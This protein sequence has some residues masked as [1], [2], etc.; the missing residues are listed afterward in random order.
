MTEATA[1]PATGSNAGSGPAGV[2]PPAAAGPTQ[3]NPVPTFPLLGPGLR[4]ARRPRVAILGRDGSGRESIFRAAAST[5]THHERLA[6]IGP[7]YE[8][9]LVEVGLD[10]ISL[11]ALP[12]IA[13]SHSRQEEGRVT[14]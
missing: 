12:P 8:E 11:V 6:G 3:S 5:T 10:Q 14:L 7:A 13:G 9:C 2:P 1:A 4:G